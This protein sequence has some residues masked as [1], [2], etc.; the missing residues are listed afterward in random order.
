M[1]PRKTYHD[2]TD[3]ENILKL[4]EV[5]KTLPHFARDYFRAIDATTTTRTRISYAYDIRLFFQF[6]VTQNPSLEGI[7]IPDLPIEV[8]DEVKA[9]DIEEYMEY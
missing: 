8:L 7:H 4:R 2:Q 5:L 1:P 6:L 9:L 3:E